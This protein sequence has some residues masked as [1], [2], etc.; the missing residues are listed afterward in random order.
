MDASIRKLSLSAVLH[1]IVPAKREG[2][3][4]P[5]VMLTICISTAAEFLLS[6]F[7]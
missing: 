6:S 7:T 4:A 5:L 1:I 2:V 3:L